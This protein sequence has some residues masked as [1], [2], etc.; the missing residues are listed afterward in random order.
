[1]TQTAE[2]STT[3]QDDYDPNSLNIADAQQRIADMIATVRETEIIPIH[4]ALNRTLATNLL[5]TINVPPQTNSAMDGYAVKFEDIRS[6]KQPQ[7]KIIG[8]AYA[9]NPFNGEINS[10]ECIR[11]MTGAIMPKNVDTVIMQEQTT[12][13]ENL[14]SINGEHSKAQNVRLQGEDLQI[15]EAALVAG[16]RLKPT[17]IGI[18]ASLGIESIEVYRRVKA[19]IFSTGDE[20][21]N[22][23]DKLENGQIFDSNRYTILS[24]LQQLNIEITDLGIIK[25]DPETTKQAFLTAKNSHD[26]LITSGGVSVGDADYV[27]QTLDSLGEIN[28]WK[29]AMK[30]GRP[31]A[32]GKLDNTYFFGLPGNPVSAAVT[33]YQIVQ[34]ALRQLSGQNQTQTPTLKMKCISKLKKRPGRI[35]FQR[36]IMEKS[37]NGEFLVKSTGNQG[38]HVLSSLNNANC[39]IILDE[40]RGDVEAGEQVEVQPFYGIL[41]F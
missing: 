13:Q 28:F 17:D 5:S 41:G 32:V 12:V 20:L 8:V 25:D 3:C 35:E 15:G 27:K 37:E 30:P 40:K 18:I 9:G 21:K 14:L 24:L 4:D 31:L 33:F 10:G 6:N 36:G 38:S 2:I 7:L 34:P 11:I 19:A 29:I 16:T 1:M 26:V 22:I 39:F 23:G